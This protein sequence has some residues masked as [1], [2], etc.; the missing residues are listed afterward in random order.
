MIAPLV[1]GAASLAGALLRT[2]S[3]SGAVRR[4]LAVLAAGAAILFAVW[5]ALDSAERRG[6]QERQAEIDRET[7]RRIDD[8][9]R[10]ES[11][12][13]SGSARDRRLHGRFD[14]D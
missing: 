9:N 4:A 10:A 7:L 1:T 14:R 12:A 13:N 5:R 8:A 2:L 6:A 11:D 3:G